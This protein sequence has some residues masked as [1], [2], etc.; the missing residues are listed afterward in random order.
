M[1]RKRRPSFIRI[2]SSERR[3][4]H[5]EERDVQE[6]QEAVE[7]QAANELH[8][9]VVVPRE[10]RGRARWPELDIELR[11]VRYGTKSRTPY[12]RVVPRE[13]R[14]T[15]VA[16]G[17]IEATRLASRPVGRLGRYYAAAKELL[18]GA[19]FQT[20]QTIHERLS[21]TKALAIFSSDALSSSAYATEQIL[22]VLLAA[23]STAL[24]HSLPISAF[25]ILLLAIVTISYRQTVKYYPSGGGAYSVAHA[26]LGRWAGLLAAA[27]L[28]VDYIL[29]VSVS[30]AAGVAAVTSAAPALHELRV[31]IG[32]AVIA[33]ITLGNLRGLRE[34]GTVFAIP[35]YIFITLMSTMILVGLTKVL[36]GD[37]PGDL[38]SAA[39]PR[40]AASAGQTLSLL[41]LMRAFAAGCSG[42][43]G[44]EAIS[45][46]VPAFK[47]PE[48]QNA[49]A[50]LAMMGG[51]LAF[52]LL[53][54]A[55]L[56]TRYGIVP[57]SDETAVS[58]LGRLVLGENVIYYAYQAA[59][60]L[61]LFLAANTSYAGFPLMAA[62]L[63]KD[64]FLPRQFSFRGDRLAY[65][66]GIILL[67]ITAAV[68][69]IAFGGS[70]H[71]LIPLY[72]LGVFISFTLSQSGMV[73]H[74]RRLAE[75]SW[76]KNASI[77]LIGAAVT[78]IVA[79]VIGLTRFMAGAWISLLIMGALIVLFWAVRRHYNS[80]Y[81]TIKPEEA[82][83]PAV[84]PRAVPVHQAGPHNH[85]VVPVDDI[86]RITASAVA[87]AREISTFVTAVHVTDDR[88]QAEEFR[89]H[90]ERTAP[91]VPLLIIE[92]P[93]RAF[94]GPMLA[95][96]QSLEA[97][98]PGSVITVIL[99][100]LASLPWWARLLHNQEVLRLRPLLTGRQRVKVVDFPWRLED[101]AP[102]ST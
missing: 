30:V 94:V 86:N 25:I 75:A 100:R 89:N 78:G 39:Q 81:R 8:T 28:F 49:R 9:R 34:A 101:A 41:L 26:N 68:L 29:T 102:A 63:A 65:S 91:D 32:V 55:F 70:E 57:V 85:A 79:I 83:F 17:V 47:P 2:K 44:V 88:Q 84:G 21:K 13:R 38:T 4:Q 24:V 12:L 99:P 64:G 53:G 45:N 97:A 92:S 7:E 16:P 87:F 42:L 62:V 54:I 22:L 33:L 59:T 56:A 77:S 14:F 20:A 1:E 23:G 95:Y 10:E 74:L 36:L 61:V 71:R 35:T 69:L 58:Q 66:N 40:E 50:T 18:I 60:A 5:E 80:F 46:G 11:E 98:E 82:P 43:T 31:P 19:P 27:A 67:A 37:A 3:P 52:F 90:W 76:K 93:Y 96:V 15:P 6:G 48:S 51:I 72:A 73:V